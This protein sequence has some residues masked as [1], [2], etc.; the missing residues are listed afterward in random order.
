MLIGSPVRG[1]RPVE[2]LRLATENVPKPTRRTSSPP[3]RAP[4]IASN[5]PSI[6]LVASPRV[7]PL[8]SATVLI[9]SFLFIEKPPT[10]SET[11]DCVDSPHGWRGIERVLWTLSKRNRGPNAPITAH[12]GEF[13]DEVR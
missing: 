3:F 2:A 8:D 12:F 6:A 11:G 9:R 13:H 4:E 1:L 10:F 5:T 7:R